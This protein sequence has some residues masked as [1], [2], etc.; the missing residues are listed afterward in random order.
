MLPIMSLL[1]CW[2]MCVF[3]FLCARVRGFVHARVC[4]CN[5][6][7]FVVRF[8][9]CASVFVCLCACVFFY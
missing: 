4:A 6:R 7:V 1:R 5:V 3:I 8:V 9:L 2:R